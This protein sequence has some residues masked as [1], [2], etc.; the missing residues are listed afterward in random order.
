MKVTAFA[1]F[2]ALAFSVKTTEAAVLVSE[3]STHQ[4]TQTFQLPIVPDALDQKNPE[5]HQKSSA[6]SS[7]REATKIKRI[8]D[9][10]GRVQKQFHPDGL[11]DLYEY[12]PDDQLRI[13]IKNGRVVSVQNQ[14]GKRMR[15]LEEPQR[16]NQSPSNKHQIIS[17]N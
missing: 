9:S 17:N 1:L 4:E 6:D 3:S 2:I 12:L 10:L 7:I 11:I 15:V 5:K 8:Y 16:N 13:Q 14:E